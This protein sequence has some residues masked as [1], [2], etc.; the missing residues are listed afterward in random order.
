MNA[1][2]DNVALA[3]TARTGVNETGASPDR[4]R[5][6]QHGGGRR[7]V[8]AG[9][10]RQRLVRQ[11][12]E[13]VRGGCSQRLQRGRPFGPEIEPSGPACMG[14]GSRIYDVS[15]WTRGTRR[16]LLTHFF[17][18]AGRRRKRK[19]EQE[20]K[21]HHARKKKDAG[22]YEADGILLAITLLRRANGLRRLP[23]Q[24][25]AHAGARARTRGRLVCLAAGRVLCGLSAAHACAIR[26]CAWQRAL[27]TAEIGTHRPCYWPPRRRR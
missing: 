13:G 6:Q 8:A 14:K 4:A 10:V 24:G 21:G 27:C 18:T 12:Y 23:V 20:P 25:H 5:R 9:S 26:S 19:E 22:S 7:R 17:P 16:R 2:R 1:E 15:R 3:Q 11:G